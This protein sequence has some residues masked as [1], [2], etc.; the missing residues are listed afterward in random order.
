MEIAIF[1]ADCNNITAQTKAQHLAQRLALPLV[2]SV[3]P[4]MA[5]YL[6]VEG[7]KLG[8]WIPSVAQKP[9]YVDF[10]AGKIAERQAR[11]NM[12][13]E[14]IVKACQVKHLHRPV[15][16]IDTTA[17]FGRDAFI[18]AGAGAEVTMVERNAVVATLLQDGLTRL[19][20][21]QPDYPL[22]LICSDAVRY[23]SSSQHKSMAD[24][25]YLDP[26]FAEERRAKVKKD[27]QLLQT[28]LAHESADPV[29]LFE[30][31]YQS[32]AKKIVVKRAL[33]ADPIV[34]LQP[35][36]MV[37]GKHTRFDIYLRPS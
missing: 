22:S 32:G 6:V 29:T 7:D 4:E 5:I 23:L 25:V 26:M 14:L 8:L 21:I 33:Y 12:Q 17:G 35:N 28:L 24:V 16:I 9:Y 19:H 10:L 1:C 2:T 37:S 3:A 27:L 18:L 31:A 30:A 15:K 34:N 20:E 11:Q 36:F 13:K